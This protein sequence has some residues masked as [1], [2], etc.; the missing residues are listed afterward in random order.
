MQGAINLNCDKALQ[1]YWKMKNGFVK[2]DEKVTTL[3]YTSS[4]TFHAETLMK[5]FDRKVWKL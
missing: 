1:S 2:E 5:P 4:T 3:I